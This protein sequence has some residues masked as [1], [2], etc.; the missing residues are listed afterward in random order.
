MSASSDVPLF[1]PDGDGHRP[2]AFARG[3][4]DPGL[5]H[6]GAVGALVSE[7]LQQ[8]IDPTY[9]PVR[10]TLDL[11]RP[12]PMQRLVVTPEVLRTGTRLASVRATVTA[13][14]KAVAVAS[15][16]ALRPAPLD[17]PPNPPQPPPD[18]PA[19]A[20]DRW[21]MSIDDEA[22]LGGAMSFRFA[23]ADTDRS[24]MWLHL[25][26]A[27][28]PGAAPTPLARA[29]AAADV[30]SAV[31]SFEGIRYEGVGFINADVSLHLHRP[32]EGEWVRVTSMSRW[33]PTGI[34]TV[35]A[36]LGD[37][38]G[39]AGTVSQGLIL[40]AGLTPPPPV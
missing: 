29:A 22:F 35:A 2:T 5:L 40:A 21:G 30:P 38:A 20:E 32:I 19:G 1:E 18:L 25:H 10:L 33:E 24:A 14:G 12:V 27:V 4:W 37:T 17:G 9:Q 31:S 7:V 28:L 34:G 15:L 8:Q 23:I 16:L 39:R 13:G 36:T 3:P 26:R 6:G 11:I